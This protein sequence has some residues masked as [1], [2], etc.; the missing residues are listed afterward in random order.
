MD[1]SKEWMNKDYLKRFLIGYLLEEVKEGDK[2]TRWKEGVLRV[3]EECGLRDG[4]SM[5]RFRWRLGVE[6]RCHAS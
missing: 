1:I 3:M 6:I 5:D 4:D 2:K